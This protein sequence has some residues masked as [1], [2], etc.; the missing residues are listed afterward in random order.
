M[1]SAAGGAVLG[2]FHVM[3][4][5]VGALGIFSWPAFVDITTNDA[6][7]MIIAVIVS[8]AAMAASFVVTFLTYTDE[9]GKR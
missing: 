2:A 6:S 8:L 3:Q 9:A 1:I 7:G 5:S 4:Y